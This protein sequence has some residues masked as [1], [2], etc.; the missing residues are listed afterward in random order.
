MAIDALRIFDLVYVL[1]GGCPGGS[2]ETL[3]IHAYKV[4]FYKGDFGQGGA[5]SVIILLLVGGFGYFCTKK[6]FEENKL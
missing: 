2:T 4:F 5:I 1:T 6:S 3:S